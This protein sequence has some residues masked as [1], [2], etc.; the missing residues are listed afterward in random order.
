MKSKYRIIEID[1]SFYVQKR[2]LWIWW[3]VKHRVGDFDANYV[4]RVAF[5]TQQAARDFV[6]AKLRAPKITLLNEA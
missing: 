3:F 2:F 1:G 6:V 5:N 4:E